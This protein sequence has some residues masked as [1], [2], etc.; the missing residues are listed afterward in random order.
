M[1]ITRIHCEG[2]GFP[3]VYCKCVPKRQSPLARAIR[4]VRDKAIKGEPSK[5]HWKGCDGCSQCLSALIPDEEFYAEE[6]TK[7][8]RGIG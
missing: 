1:S 3:Q 2:C 4:G 6:F 5:P 8:E 7:I